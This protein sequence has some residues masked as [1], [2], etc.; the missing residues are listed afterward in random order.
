M[1]VILKFHDGNEDFY[2]LVHLCK[3]ILGT[4]NV[5][6]LFI[7]L[8]TGLFLGNGREAKYISFPGGLYPLF[9]ETALKAIP[10]I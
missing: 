3:V 7:E 8:S 1:R 9:D 6:L 5:L 10:H 4:S 2:Q